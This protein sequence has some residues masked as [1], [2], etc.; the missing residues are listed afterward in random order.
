MEQVVR[1]LTDRG[2]SGYKEFS[3]SL[4]NSQTLAAVLFRQSKSKKTITLSRISSNGNGQRSSLIV[5]FTAL[6]KG[7]FQWFANGKASANSES[8]LRRIVA[9]SG[10]FK[11]PRNVGKFWALNGTL[12][13]NNAP[14]PE[15][16][17][18]RA[19]EADKRLRLKNAPTDEWQRAPHA[20][21]RQSQHVRCN[22]NMGFDA[23]GDDDWSCDQ[24]RAASHDTGRALKKNTAIKTESLALDTRP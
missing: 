24:R 16:M 21:K 6:G 8:H 15:P 1:S 13:N 22:C 10:E 11:V 23:Q 20:H 5:G 14:R 17:I 9:L 19:T 3:M 12:S 18:V 2:A 4:C 7:D